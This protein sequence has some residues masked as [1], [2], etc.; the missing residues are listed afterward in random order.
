MSSANNACVVNCS[1]IN[2]YK[3]ADKNKCVTDC[4]TEDVTYYLSIDK[5]NCV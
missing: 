3:N 5:V 2:E 1:L 4:H